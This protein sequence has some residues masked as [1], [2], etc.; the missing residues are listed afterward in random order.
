MHVQREFEN[1]RGGRLRLRVGVS[2]RLRRANRRSRNNLVIVHM[3]RQC[4]TRVRLLSALMFSLHTSQLIE[5]TLEPNPDAEDDRNAPAEKLALSFSTADVV[6]LGWRLYRISVV[7]R[8]NDLAS[9]HVLPKRY[10]DYDSAQ[11][12]VA[13]ITVTPVGKDTIHSMTNPT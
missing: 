7:L 13:S 10:G 1:A 11:P 5:Y 3:G 2:Y 9:V 4:G 6:I 8:E 12:Y